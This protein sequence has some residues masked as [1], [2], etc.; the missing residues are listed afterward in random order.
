MPF[1]P[2]ILEI[3]N[4]IETEF[5]ASSYF[6]AAASAVI[7]NIPRKEIWMVGDC[8]ALIG[9]KYYCPKKK[10][11]TLLAEARSLAIHAFLEE[12]MTEKELLEHDK[13]REIILPFLKMQHCFENKPGP[14]GY[15]VFN[16]RSMDKK[17]LEEQG[18]VVSITT[19]ATI[20]LASDGYPCLTDSFEETEEKLAKI[21]EEDA[22]C[23]KTNKSTKGIRTDC[24]SFDDRTYVK[25]QISSEF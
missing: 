7:Y 2:T 13:G 18:V 8:Q 10:V 19:P 14:Y 4:R 17:I 11:D 22:L 23:Y 3:Q 15:L 5:P 25:I 9:D 16:N 1:L 12:G 20:V 24:E 6:P 21:L